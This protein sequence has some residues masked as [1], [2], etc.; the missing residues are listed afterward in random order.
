M[1]IAARQQIRN[2][3]WTGTVEALATDIMRISADT[4]INDGE[5]CARFMELP[6]VRE[7]VGLQRRALGRH[8]LSDAVQVAKAYVETIR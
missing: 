5:Q 1:D 7:Y 2:L 3:V 6:T 4:T 8:L